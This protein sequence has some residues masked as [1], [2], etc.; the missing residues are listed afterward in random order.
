MSDNSIYAV[1]RLV[2]DINECSWYHTMDVPGYGVMKGQW[3]LREGVRD[4]LGN[5]HF[6]GKR[7]M[8]VGT[9]SG[10]LCFY[11]ES[12]GAEVV[13][14]DVSENHDWDVVPFYNMENE[15][16]LAERRE[17]IRRLNNA[18]W[19]GHRAFNSNARMVYGTV[20]MIPREIGM[21][22]I[23]VFGSILIHLRD[24]F[25]ALQNAL[26]L[27]K[28]T[29]I[30]TQNVR[31][32][33][34]IHRRLHVLPVR[35]LSLFSSPH[36]KFVPAPRMP[37]YLWWDISPEIVKRMI[38]VLGFEDAAVTYH[39]QRYYVGNRK[40]ELYTVVGHRT[41]EHYAY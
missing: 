36:M 14:Y 23:S 4:Y 37:Q 41:R 22:D 7:V 32:I 21:V 15:Q 19:L 5:V 1:P 9:A 29:V 11:M 40:I 33:R 38:A 35:L 17:G 13:A 31:E 16:S 34:R 30:I 24:P 26:R 3:D 2:T 20:Y 12:K 25:L 6:E 28:E 8:D 27:T 39:K 18:Y 10:F